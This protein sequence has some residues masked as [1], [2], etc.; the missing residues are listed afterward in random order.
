[1]VKDYNLFVFKPDIEVLGLIVKIAAAVL[2][3]LAL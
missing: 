3:D 2:F 1:V